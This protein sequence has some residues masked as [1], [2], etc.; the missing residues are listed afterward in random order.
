MVRNDWTF[1]FMSECYQIERESGHIIKPNKKI[2]VRRH[3]DGSTS[4]WYKDQQLMLK[5]LTKTP[6]PLSEQKASVIP[7]SSSTA[8]RRGKRK[9]AW[10]QFNTNWLK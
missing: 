8:G 10:A 9:S 1:S 7:L 6:D 3:L 4:A 5:K 2:L